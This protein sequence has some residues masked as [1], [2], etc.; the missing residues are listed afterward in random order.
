MTKSPEGTEER[1]YV[2]PSSLWRKMPPEAGP[3]ERGLL[4]VRPGTGGPA[5]ESARPSRLKRE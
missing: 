3:G 4:L 5:T 1:W 2:M